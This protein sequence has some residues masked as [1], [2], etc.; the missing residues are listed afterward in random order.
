[1]ESIQ[2]RINGKIGMAKMYLDDAIKLNKLTS[3]LSMVVL[4]EKF[5]S[6]VL[7]DYY[8]PPVLKVHLDKQ[9]RYAIESA[10]RMFEMCNVYFEEKPTFENDVATLKGTLIENKIK[11][12]AIH[13]VGSP[14]PGCEIVYEEQEVPEEVIVKPAHTVIKARVI[15]PED[16]PEDD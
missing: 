14:P 10:K 8:N 5:H 13:L 7:Q 11:V 9:N 4:T 3:C 16:R 6:V 1:M 2:D 12:L 15:C